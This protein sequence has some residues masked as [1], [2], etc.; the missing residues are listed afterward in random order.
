MYSSSK[1]TDQRIPKV[2]EQKNIRKVIK[3]F[4]FIFKA[5]AFIDLPEALKVT[6]SDI[7]ADKTKSFKFLPKPLVDFLLSVLPSEQR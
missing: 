2:A 3:N 7:T 1:G 4:F 6:K 5:I